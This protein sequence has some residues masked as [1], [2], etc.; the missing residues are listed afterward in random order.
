MFRNQFTEDRFIAAME[1]FVDVYSTTMKAASQTTTEPPATFDNIRSLVQQ[2]RKIEAIK[3][4][5]QM[6]GA[7]LKDAK[8]QVDSIR[9][10]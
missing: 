10:Y 7:S 1:K 4:F 6:T 9:L 3:L 5:R 8:D 2:G